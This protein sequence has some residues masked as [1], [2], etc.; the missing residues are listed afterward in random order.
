MHIALPNEIDDWN[1]LILELLTTVNELYS[2]NEDLFR[3][4]QG[5]PD[6]DINVRQAAETAHENLLDS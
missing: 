5:L 4:V 3:G 1:R 6:P 2:N